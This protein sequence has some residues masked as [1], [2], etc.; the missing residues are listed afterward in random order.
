MTG[1]LFAVMPQHS[2]LQESISE[3]KYDR[4]LSSTDQQAF[5]LGLEQSA[6]T[7]LLRSLFSV[8][9][10]QLFNRLDGKA[11]FFYLS[12]LLIGTELRSIP[13]KDDVRIMLCSGQ[14]LGGLYELALQNLGLLAQTVIIPTDKVDTAAFEGH[15]KILKTKNK[16]NY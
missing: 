1:E 12:G 5:C 15:I 14:Q 11:N 10:N 13:R 16:L 3:V 2:I 7:N 8:R 9:I 6:E 4:A